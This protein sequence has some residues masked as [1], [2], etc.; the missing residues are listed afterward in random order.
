MPTLVQSLQS[1]DIGF[2]RIVARHWGMES[3]ASDR[4]TI[5]EEIVAA[6][7]DH[8]LFVDMVESLSTDARLA[9]E[10]LANSE[11]KLPWAAFTRQFGVIREAGPGKRDREQIYL[12]PVSAAEVLFY[13]GLIARAFFDMPSGPKEF[14]YIPIDLLDL[15]KHDVLSHY[16]LKNFAGSTDSWKANH[17]S[18]TI[19]SGSLEPFGRQAT[20]KECAHPLP[21]SDR[22]LDD[23]TTLLAAFRTGLPIPVTR[24]PSGIVLDFLKAT[25]ILLPPSKKAKNGAIIPDIEAVRSFLESSREIALEMLRNSWLVSESFNELRQVPGIVCEGDWANQPSIT[26]KYLVSLLDP[27]PEHKWWNLQAFIQS[28]KKKNPDYQRPSGD[29]DSWF[30]KRESDGTYLRGFENWDEVDGALINYMITGPLYWLEFVELATPADSNIVSAFRK[31][32]G[33]PRSQLGKTSR[34]H[35]SSQGKIVVPRSISRLNRYQIAR[36]C[37]WDLDKENEYHYQVSTYSLKRAVA[38]GLKVNQLL[39]LLAKNAASE[40]PPSFISALNRWEN[41]GTEVRMEVQTIL[42][43]SHPE[44]LEELRKSKA[45]RFL[46]ETLGPVTVTIKSGAQNKVL[47]ALAEMG[48]LGEVVPE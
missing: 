15:F 19:N 22:L 23:G 3:T 45:G 9:F 18:A 2:L 37:E 38:Q 13:Q 44:V 42:K 7:L 33:T 8:K 1:H 25:N 11:G 5:L 24:I 47:A 29:Y 43:V 35:V 46:G 12:N 31:R 48:L 36:F 6:I 34:L 41:K 30:V 32:G 28:I 21:V 20:L 26:R 4:K 40:I 10:A 39:S 16:P 17:N 14:A 27:I